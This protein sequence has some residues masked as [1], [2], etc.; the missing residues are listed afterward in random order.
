MQRCIVREVGWLRQPHGGVFLDIA[1]IKTRVPNGAEHIKKKPPACFTS[2]PAFVSTRHRSRWK[3]SDDALS[4]GVK[5][6]GDT[7]SNVPACCRGE[8]PL[9]QRRQSPGGNCS[10]ILVFGKR[11]GEYAASSPRR[12]RPEQST[13]PGRRGSQAR[14]PFDRGPG[15]RVPIR[16]ALRDDAG[17]GGN[18]QKQPEMQRAM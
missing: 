9:H 5:A 4:W 6:D 15:A 11:A 16:Y 13:R 8:A 18:R 3:L 10:D 1:W 17:P 7:V 14:G 2:S 12:R